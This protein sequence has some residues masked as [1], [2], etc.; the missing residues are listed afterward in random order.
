MG[1]WD[2]PLDSG[3]HAYV[4]GRA[5]F[6]ARPA[7]SALS[8]GLGWRYDYLMT[9]SEQ[10]AEVYWRYKNQSST[11][12]SQNLPLFIEA[13]HNERVGANIGI[14]KQ[15]LPNWKLTTRANIWQGLHALDG[16]IVGDL[17]TI[18]LPA[19]AVTNIRDSLDEAHADISYY[20]DKLPLVVYLVLK[21]TLYSPW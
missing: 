19:S 21:T 5:S 14:T 7:N 1:D 12:S 9:F 11:S 2:A 17:S 15:V 13:K 16:T 8:Y 4:Q 3:D 20:Y 6:E 18:G 10:T